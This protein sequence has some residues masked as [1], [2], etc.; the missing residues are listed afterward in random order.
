MIASLR[1]SFTK[2]GILKAREIETRLVNETWLASEYDL[3]PEARRLAIP[4]LVIHGE[5]DLVPTECAAHI[6]HAIPGARFV[7]L[8]ECGHFAYLE[9]PDDVFREVAEFFL[10]G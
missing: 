9:R 7:V 2:E 1:G 4:T 5:Y 6:A 8:K 10:G 3:L